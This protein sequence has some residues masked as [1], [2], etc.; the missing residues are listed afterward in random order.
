MKRFLCIVIAFVFI[1][2]CAAVKNTAAYSGEFNEKLYICTMA[3]TTIE[4]L[5]PYSDSYFYRNNKEYSP[6]TSVLSLA[7][8]MSAFSSPE[9]MKSSDKNKFSA[10]NNIRKTYKSMGFINAEFYNYNVPVTNMDDKVAFAFALKEIAGPYGKKDTLLSVIVRGGNYG[11]EWVSNFHIFGDY[12]TVDGNLEH[13]GFRTAAK[14]VYESLNEYIRDNMSSFKGD[15]KLWISGYSRGAAVA[16]LLSH[17]INARAGSKSDF[18][19]RCVTPENI[20]SYQ[21]ACPAGA[22]ESDVNCEV[23]KNIFVINSPSDVIPMMAPEKWGFSTYGNIIYLP[24][25]MTD[26]AQQY[27]NEILKDSKY[28]GV[29]PCSPEHTQTINQI[30]EVVTDSVSEQGYFTLQSSIM[31]AMASSFEGESQNSPGDSIENNELI[32]AVSNLIKLKYDFDLQKTINNALYAHFPEHY[33]SLIH[34]DVVNDIYNSFDDDSDNISYLIGD[35][36][37]D[38]QITLEDV[39]EIQKYLAKLI[40]FNVV[41]NAVADASRD[42]EISLDDVVLIQKYIAQLITQFE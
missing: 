40:D 16:N 33:I 18:V 23:D 38:G 3:D 10:D 24:D 17:S 42:G 9:Y 8:S 2:G 30:L 34:D 12:D 36:N 7:M 26:T 15:V 37:Q 5:C 22:R 19:S 25:T 39:V 11:G 21:F 28:E 29:V 27:F 13:C 4:Y 41:Q 32:T 20:Y 14:Q 6:K 1:L 35:V 31:K